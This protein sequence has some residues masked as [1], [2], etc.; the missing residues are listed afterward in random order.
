MRHHLLAERSKAILLK[1]NQSMNKNHSLFFRVVNLV[2]F[3]I[4]GGETE[5]HQSK[6]DIG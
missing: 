1:E 6:S 2:L 5:P 4:D 3:L